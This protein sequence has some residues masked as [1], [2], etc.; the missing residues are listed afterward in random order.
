MPAC[1]DAVAALRAGADLDDGAGAGSESPAELSA[2]PNGVVVQW[3]NA[4]SSG[5]LSMYCVLGVP[6]GSPDAKPVFVQVR[7]FSAC[8]RSRLFAVAS[9][10]VFAIGHWLLT[11][12]CPVCFF[13]CHVH[14]SARLMPL[15]SAGSRWQRV[16]C[17][18][19]VS[20]P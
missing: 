18:T 19:R 1:A 17:A 10:G 2:P 20:V 5:T 6:D 12:A 8:R 16:T 13:P 4:A 11:P 14:R 3:Y 7:L 15:L 9:P